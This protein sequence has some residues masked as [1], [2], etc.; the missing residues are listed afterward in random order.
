MQTHNYQKRVTVVAYHASCADGFAAATVAWLNLRSQAQY[1]AVQ[2]NQPLPEAVTQGQPEKALLFVD[3]CPLPEELEDLKGVWGDVLVID[4]HKGHEW[5]KAANPDKCIF[6]LNRSG[7]VLTHQ[8]FAPHQEVP[9]F[10]RYI[11]DR[12]LWKWELENSR[13]LSAAVQQHV[14]SFEVWSS[15]LLNFSRIKSRLV[16]QGKTVLAAQKTVFERTAKTA[17]RVMIGDTPVRAVNCT[18]YISETC[19]HI[20][21]LY[22]DVDI[23]LGFFLIDADQVVLSFRSREGVECM[24]LAKSLGGG[25]HP[26]AAGAKISLQQLSEVLRHG[27]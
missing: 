15:L 17:K 19:E 18:A 25:G 16:S 9:E 2:Y 20:L 3:F 4:H 12:D 11:E 24:P 26:R 7:A 14:H 23:A 5:V 10:L 1:V 8:W 6:D 13:S 27:K 22:S 21:R